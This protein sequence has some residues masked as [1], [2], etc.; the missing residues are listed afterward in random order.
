MA[1]K[2]INRLWL[3]ESMDFYSEVIA[4]IKKKKPTKRELGTVK[5]KLSK[6]YKLASAPTDI[7]ILLHANEKDNLTI[8]KEYSFSPQH[9]AI[10]CHVLDLSTHPHVTR[11]ACCCGTMRTT[12]LPVF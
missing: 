3:L 2:F 7:E 5:N 12:R 4:Y 10:E 6:K 1:V 11:H 9:S 8:K